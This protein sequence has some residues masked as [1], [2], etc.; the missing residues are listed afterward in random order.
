MS[1]FGDSEDFE[2]TPG[3]DDLPNARNTPPKQPRPSRDQGQP[4][5]A[6]RPPM[7]NTGQ[8]AKTAPTRVSRP[9]NGVSA[10]GSMPHASSGKKKA[11]LPKPPPAR[12]PPPP[13]PEINI[14]PNYPEH[15]RGLPPRPSSAK[16]HTPS[17]PV[18]YSPEP[19]EYSPEPEYRESTL[20]PA[21]TAETSTPQTTYN[22][23]RNV[24]DSSFGN[25]Y[26]DP[27]REEQSYDP[28]KNLPPSFNPENNKKSYEPIGTE[29]W[30]SADRRE[31]PSRNQR[32]IVVEDEDPDEEDFDPPARG[33]KKKVTAPAKS[34]KKGSLNPFAKKDTEEKPV[35]RFSGGRK[36]VIVINSIVGASVLFAIGFGLNA[37][38]N[39]PYIPTPNDMKSL[40]SEQLNVTKFD[41]DGG[42]A[43]VSSFAKEYFT[44]TENS[45]T[46]KSDRL[47]AYA[48]EEVTAALTSSIEVSTG[49]TQS[50]SGEPY[51]T[52]IKAINDNNAIYNIGTKVGKTWVYMDVPVFYDERTLAYT[53]SGVPSFTPPPSVAELGE[54]EEDNFETDSALS[55]ETEEIAVGFFKAWGNSDPNQISRFTVSEADAKT[56]GGLH[57]T[58]K[59][60]ELEDY[61][62][63][64]K[65]DNDP[66]V[67][68]RKAKATVVWGNASSKATVK[69]A[70][71][72]DMK[73]YQQPDGRW[74]VADISTATD[75]YNLIQESLPVDTP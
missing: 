2:L 74:Y 4:N 42:R 31:Q 58:A 12:T 40:V 1:I 34:S 29:T 3:G 26:R 57:K 15:S 49:A 19:V 38:F 67:T 59:F 30:E 71:T 47:S 21:A 39:P 14:E 11:T 43:F 37:V 50:V 75:E 18:E 72:F 10:T 65:E 16:S 35:S 62:V 70:Q 17:Q 41:K 33:K 46:D 8:R 44:Y 61:A 25:E 51:I 54:A 7:S 53:I 68:E 6:R 45:A 66:T 13:E 73:L 60:V 23:P 64:A 63:E 36:K 56:I 9:P 27:P 20:P 69:Y 48:S 5:E 52:N 28:P 55:T 32:R 24:P 22:P